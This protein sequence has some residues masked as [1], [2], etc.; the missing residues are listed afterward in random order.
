MVFEHFHRGD[1]YFVVTLWAGLKSR[2]KTSKGFALI[3]F[4]QKSPQY[5]IFKTLLC[6]NAL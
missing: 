2:E 3:D 1:Q 6:P 4:C 5:T